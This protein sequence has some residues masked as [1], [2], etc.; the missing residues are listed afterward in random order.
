MKYTAKR[1]LCWLIA[2]LL[3]AAV[4]GFVIGCTDI[5][6]AEND[7]ATIMRSFMGYESG[8]PATFSIMI[9]GLLAIPLGLISTAFPD[10]PWFTYA[11]L[12]MLAL[13]CLIISKSILQIFVRHQKPLWL[14]A[15]FAAMF[16]SVLCMK[17]ITELTFTITA[18]ALAA[19]AVLQMFSIDH[20]RG[21]W[22]VV[23]GMLGAL[24]LVLLSFALR[25]EGVLAVLAFCGLAFVMIVL[26]Q[27]G[28]GKQAKRSLLPMV[29]SLVI[30]SILFIIH[31]FF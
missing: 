3:T 21:A 14:G 18:A 25:Y 20:D 8:E 30:K 1:A 9:H 5:T 19:A 11:Q 27:Y 29:I 16:V 13:S 26:S 24:G 15:V 17:H 7:D 28:L 22:R 10:L 31:C 4:M 23:V 2:A 12:A 6:Y